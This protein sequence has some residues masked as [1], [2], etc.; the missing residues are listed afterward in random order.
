MRFIFSLMRKII[1]YICFSSVFAALCATLLTFAY[2]YANTPS[3]RYQSLPL[4]I[5]VFGG[6]LT[7][8]SL[9]YYTKSTTAL[10]TERNLWSKQHQRLLLSLLT[11]G[12]IASV[13]GFVQLHYRTQLFTACSAVLALAYSFPIV[14]YK[15]RNKRLKEFGVLKP[16]LLASVWVAATTLLPLMELKLYDANW[17]LECMA[18]FLLIFPLCILF[19]LKDQAVDAQAHIKTIPNRLNARQTIGIC[20][21]SASLMMIL[22]GINCLYNT[23][24]DGIAWVI[25]AVLLCV[26]CHKAIK[27]QE[28]LYYVYKVDGIMLL[29]GMAQVIIVWIGVA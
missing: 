14:P 11:L 10:T 29:Y 19:D 5:M 15:K 25:G 13:W 27:P 21:L 3:I 2:V 28:D 24:S 17:A 6:T 23:W 22:F 1:E 9:H 4:L 8:Y 26:L 12:I 20:Y 18:R 7:V 16:F